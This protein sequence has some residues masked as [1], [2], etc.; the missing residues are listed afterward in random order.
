[1]IDNVEVLNTN[2]G[3]NYSQRRLETI[4]MKY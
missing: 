2:S 4:E 1:M 3:L